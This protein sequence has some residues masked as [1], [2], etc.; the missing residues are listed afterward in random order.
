MRGL[1]IEDPRSHHGPLHVLFAFRQR[2]LED[3]RGHAQALSFFDA[4][5]ESRRRGPWSGCRYFA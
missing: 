2:A 1:P 4:R 3:F 5:P